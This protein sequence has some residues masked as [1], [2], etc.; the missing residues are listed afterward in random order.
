MLRSATTGLRLLGLAACLAGCAPPPPAPAVADRRMPP[1]TATPAMNMFG[2]VSALPA[3]RANPDLA[4]DFMDLSFRMESGRT[5]PRLSRY[6]GPITVAVAG[7]APRYLVTDLDALLARLRTE[8]GIDIRRAGSLADASIVI[9]TLPR[10]RMQRQVPDAACFVV[11]RVG[12][13]SEFR[14]ARGD[15]TLD[16]TTLA[17]R[18]RAAIFIP[19]DV[20]PQEVR[21]C[22]HEEVAQALGP[23]NDLYRLPDSVFNDDN[24]HAVLTGTDMLW[25]R[26]YYDD[27]LA[28]GMGAQQVR[29]ALPGILARLNP[30]GERAGTGPAGATPRGWITGLQTALSGREPTARRI[31]AARRAVA[32][33][34][35]SGWHDNRMA[36]ALFAYG[37]LMVAEDA[38]VSLRAFVQAAE[39][40]E[41]IAP[42]GTQ[43]AH[44][45]MQLAAFA[46]SG[47]QA[48]SALDLISEA[49]PVAARSQNA[50]LLS[51]LL[52]IR[53]EALDGLGRAG[54]AREVRRDGVAWGRYAFG[55]EA[56]LRARLG[57]VAAL[58]PVTGR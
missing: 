55:A 14:A 8:A 44:V 35:Q 36:F 46:L 53:A 56:A 19:A 25:L 18:E 34:R 24:F 47:G 23:L 28:S 45:N 43:L 16:W 10:T 17:T 6:E 37:R 5:I 11:P 39:I 15:G 58:N 41:R 4:R 7:G 57:E 2:A 48:A 13:W 51:T 40:Y 33:A 9:E 21:D 50:A 42:G 12:S 3:T 27:A 30:A 26:A 20:P 22:L 31:A 38:E 49:L 1:D 32:I 29:A 52:M 54:E